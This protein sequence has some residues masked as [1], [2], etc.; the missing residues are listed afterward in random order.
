MGGGSAISRIYISMLH[1]CS[2]LVPCCQGR[3]Y[4]KNLTVTEIM[5]YNYIETQQV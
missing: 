5:L 3:N 1:L 2:K 4:K